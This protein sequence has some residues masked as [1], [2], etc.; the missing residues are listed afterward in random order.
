ML[1]FTRILPTKVG[2][3]LFI[4]RP[5]KLTGD[6]IHPRFHSEQKHDGK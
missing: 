5:L 1:R 3:G 6:G 4:N 2:H